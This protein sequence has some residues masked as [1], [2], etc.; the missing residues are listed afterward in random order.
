MNTD[1]STVAWADPDATERQP[2]MVRNTSERD[3]TDVPV[4]LT[5][6]AT[7]DVAA[8]EVSFTDA[9]AAPLSFEIEHWEPG[10]TSTVWVKLPEVP[11]F[12]TPTVWAYF[13]GGAAG[14]DPTDVWSGGYALVEH[15]DDDL[16]GGQQ[17][18]DSTGNAT[19]TL[20]GGDLVAEVAD[21]G[22]RGSRFDGS[23]LEY[24]GDVGE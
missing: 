22:T 21:E 13:G 10:A 24:A 8:D 17:R 9:A 12:T 20:I 4:R 23:R 7:P 16:A 3:F 6:D 11:K 18:Q 1:G 14:N 5:L 15:F 2:I 19:G